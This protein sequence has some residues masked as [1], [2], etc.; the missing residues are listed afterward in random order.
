[1]QEDTN[2]YYVLQSDHEAE[3]SRLQRL[4]R[5]AEQALRY[6]KCFGSQGDVD[7]GGENQGKSVSFFIERC[8]DSIAAEIVESN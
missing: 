4:L 2:G 3:V 8:I 1:M 6:A 5:E 7:D